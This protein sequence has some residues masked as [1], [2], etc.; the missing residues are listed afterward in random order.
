M[1]SYEA[2][3]LCDNG[4]CCER[5][6]GIDAHQ[7]DVAK[8]LAIGTASRRGWTTRRNGDHFCG[9]CSAQADKKRKGGK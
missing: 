3:V 4:D 8:T 2:V 6:S 9:T 7:P 5:V 1:I